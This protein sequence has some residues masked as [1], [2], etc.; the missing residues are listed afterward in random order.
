MIPTTVT[1]HMARR[2]FAIVFAIFMLVPIVI[3]LISS[4]TAEDYLRFPPH[5][6][7]V[8][9]YVAAFRNSTFLEAIIYSFEIATVVAAAAG[10]LGA[11]SALAL[12]RNVFPGRGALLGLIMMPLALPHI[13]IAIALLQLFSLSSLPIAPYGLV[14]GHVIVVTPFVVRLTMTS[15][16]HLDR[17]LELASYSLGASPW[18]T[19]RY[20]TLPLIMPGLAAGIVLAFLLSFDEV[21]LSIFL[22]LPGKTPL[23]VELFNY[24]SQGD[25]P[26]VTAAS[27]LMI[28]F[29]AA[30]VLIIERVFGV[31]RLISNEQPSL[32]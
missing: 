19:L 30:L 7:G 9:W 4:F 11:S 18:Q 29:A 27:G 13:V 5:V 2:L 12:T 8:R 16:G 22:S 17:Q 6:Y 10:I 26:V 3:V 28:L 23:P 21:T 14:A 24:A 25:D 31:L 1:W 15:L 32:P 20:L